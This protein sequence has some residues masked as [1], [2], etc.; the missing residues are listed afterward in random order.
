MDGSMA[1]IILQKQPLCLHRG[2]EKESDSA[3]DS[4]YGGEMIRPMV[5]KYSNASVRNS[6]AYF[7]QKKTIMEI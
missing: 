2:E 6:Q 7:C 5:E 4:Y 3:D 1:F